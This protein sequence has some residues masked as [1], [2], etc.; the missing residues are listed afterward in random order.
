MQSSTY[1]LKA[2]DQFNKNKSEKKNPRNL[3]RIGDLQNKNRKLSCVLEV[4]T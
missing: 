2:G 3:N 4:F 1:V